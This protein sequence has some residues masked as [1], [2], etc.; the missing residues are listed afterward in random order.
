[1]QDSYRQR[2]SNFFNRRTAYDTEA[3]G[4]PQN[5]RRLLNYA[6]VRS[7]HKVLD[8]C[9][10]TGLVAIP[11][12]KIVGQKGS[13]VGVDWFSIPPRKDRSELCLN[14]NRS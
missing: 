10:G 14:T 4:H 6:T 12:A 2:I 7:S 9:T 8:L 5:A 3:R 11:A 1:M 13:V